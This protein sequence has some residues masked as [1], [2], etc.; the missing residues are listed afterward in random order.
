MVGT[1]AWSNINTVHGCAAYRTG[2]SVEHGMAHCSV[3][4][5]VGAAVAGCQGAHLQGVDRDR[6][7]QK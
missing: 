4:L 7:L 5:K 6:A 3:L 1:A 2:M